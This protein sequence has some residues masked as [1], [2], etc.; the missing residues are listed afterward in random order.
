[1]VLRQH[2]M[3]DVSDRR[4]AR[5]TV[6]SIDPGVVFLTMSAGDGDRVGRVGY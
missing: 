6:A 2:R 4:C 3:V 5:V 1:M